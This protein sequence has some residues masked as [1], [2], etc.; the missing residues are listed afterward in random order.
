[1]ATFATC[2]QGY[3]YAKPVFI[4]NS[5]QF[6]VGEPAMSGP[7]PSSRDTRSSRL[8]FTLIELLVVIAIIGILIGLLFP[9]VQAVREA[10][11]RTS[12]QNNI[13]QLVLAT[14]NYESANR[15]FPKAYSAEMGVDVPVE[16][17]WSMR[18][19]ILPFIEEKNLHHLVDFSLPYSSQ[20]DVAAT[21]VAPFLCPS[22]I[23]DVVR[24]NA[25]GIERDYPA[26][27]A[28]NMGT[29]KIWNPNDGTIGDGAFHV[30]SR[31]TTAHF[32]DGTSQTLMFAE[33]KAYTSYLR[34]TNEDPGPVPPD[35]TTFAT[36]FTAASADINM[37][38][39]LM[40]NT[41]QTEWAD[42]LCQQ[43]GF[44]TTFSP[45]TKIPYIHA[46]TEYDIDYVS[47]REGTHST[48][49]AYGAIT[50]RSYHPGLVNVAMMD[51]SV[52]TITDQI[53]LSVW[54]ALG[55]RSGGEIIDLP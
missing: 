25:A 38:P 33:V 15:H 6:K 55:T 34:N 9:A 49:I 22:E 14:M 20:L 27:Y 53:D 40:D 41:G 31:F 24:V 3:K 23:N 5:F 32:N 10:A 26:N 30:N 4:R 1:M 54:R 43:S 7:T 18:A 37:G 16:G 28:A 50:S 2:S 35:S 8:A 12:C 52:R 46:G 48:R 44:T 51:G 47:Y 36:G 13:R 17:Q 11:R 29:W 39:N 45:N 21:R 42:G 19:R